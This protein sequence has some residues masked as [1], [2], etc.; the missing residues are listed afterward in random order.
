MC[1]GIAVCRRAAYRWD[2]FPAATSALNRA[3]CPLGT[4]RVFQAL[5]AKCLAR[6]T[7]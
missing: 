1:E 5:P 6:K 7:I 3:D 4:D 2:F